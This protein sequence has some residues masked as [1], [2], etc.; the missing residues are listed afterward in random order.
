MPKGGYY[1]GYSYCGIMPDGRKAYFVSDN[2]YLEA[3]REEE[4]QASPFFAFESTPV[5]KGV[6][7]I[8]E[9]VKRIE[10]QCKINDEI[11]RMDLSKAAKSI[12]DG[13]IFEQCEKIRHRYTRKL[14]FGSRKYFSDREVLRCANDEF[15][16]KVY[17]RII[18]MIAYCYLNGKKYF[19]L[20][21]MI[22]QAI[23]DEMML[24]FGK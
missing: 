2:E 9:E 1:T 12:I 5:V 7:F 4:N 18:H 3:Y 8:M 6:S 24:G 15:R 19:N 10:E 23:N 16:A 14:N 11:E 21:K 20:R 13:M 17:D 22:K